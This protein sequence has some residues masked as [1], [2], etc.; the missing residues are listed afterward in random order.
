[1]YPLITQIHI[2]QKWPTVDSREQTK[3]K[4]GGGDEKE[5]AEKKTGP[6]GKK[7]TQETMKR[8]KRENCGVLNRLSGE[9]VLGEG[10]QTKIQDTQLNVNFDKHQIIFSISMSH[11]TLRTYLN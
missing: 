5:E 6:D 9:S 11:A 4:G 8:G 2:P 1:M 7:R 3:D 10:C